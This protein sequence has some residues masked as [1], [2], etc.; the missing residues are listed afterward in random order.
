M[1]S[2]VIIPSRAGTKRKGEWQLK[3]RSLVEW[4]LR[5]TRGW[6][7][8]ITS[9]QRILR[10]LVDR[11]PGQRFISRP[12]HLRSEGSGQ[13]ELSLLHAIDTLGVRDLDVVHI[14]QPTSPFISADY[15]RVAEDAIEEGAASFQT[16][17][18]VPHNYHPVNQRWHDF[19]ETGFLDEAARCHA[20]T[21]Q[22]K[23]KTYAF[24]NLVSV[25]AGVLRKERWPFARPSAAFEIN[26]F[27]ALDVDSLEDLK[28]AEAYVDAGLVVNPFG[29]VL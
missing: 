3:G 5:Q 19:G 28:I 18:E 2:W 14:C 8:A 6:P 15:L 4:V 13:L 27:E 17:V 22:D 29:D 12:E 11:Y 21:K 1:Q 26:R 10:G 24:G 25:Q 23:S 7:G 9:D 16:I 20:R